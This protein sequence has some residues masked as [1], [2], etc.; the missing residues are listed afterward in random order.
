[1]PFPVCL[2]LFPVSHDVSN[3]NAPYPPCHDALPGYRLP[4]GDEDKWPRTSEMGNYGKPFLPQAF[5]LGD[6]VPMTE[7][8]TYFILSG[9]P[10]PQRGVKSSLM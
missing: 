9:S 7:S 4:G 10:G 1:M 8:L 2:S 6:F 3:D 5:Y